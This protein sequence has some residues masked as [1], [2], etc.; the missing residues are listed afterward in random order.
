MR[1]NAEG[2]DHGLAGVTRTFKNLKSSWLCGT[3]KDS[4]P[5]LCLPL[6]QTQFGGIFSLIP[7]R[8]AVPARFTA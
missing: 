6:G 8:C 7:T 1:F 4:R 5:P 3:T 2:L